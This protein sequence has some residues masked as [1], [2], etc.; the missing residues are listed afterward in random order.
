MTASL[1][2]EAI[3]FA[4]HSAI[5]LGG[6]FQKAYATSLKGK[7]IVLPLPKVGSEPTLM[8]AE[9][10]FDRKSNRELFVVKIERLALLH[11]KAGTASLD[12]KEKEEYLLYYTQ[13]FNTVNGNKDIH[14]DDLMSLLRIRQWEEG[15]V[16]V[17]KPL[18]LVAG[19]LVEVGIDYF[20]QVPGAIRSDSAQ[21]KFLKSFLNGIDEIPF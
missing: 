2:S 13:C 4:I 1:T 19:T 12:D 5:K 16:P 7:S 20:N 3:I 15:K 17:T 6:G 21:A 11:D 10:F 8:V 9:D 18:Q 14:P